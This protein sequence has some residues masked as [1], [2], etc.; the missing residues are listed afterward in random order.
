MQ[1]RY[2]LDLFTQKSMYN[3][4]KIILLKSG[5][6]DIYELMDYIL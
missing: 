5:F 4:F 2:I 6:N 3:S 1:H